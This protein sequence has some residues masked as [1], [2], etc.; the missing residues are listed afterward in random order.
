MMQVFEIEVAEEVVGEG[1]RQEMY[2]HEV[3][4]TMWTTLHC[5]QVVWVVV[6]A[7][8]VEGVGVGYS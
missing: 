5:V 6:V 7:V 8:E 2:V 3:V 4:L 1:K